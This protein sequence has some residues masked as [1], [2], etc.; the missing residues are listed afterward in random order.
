MSRWVVVLSYFILCHFISSD[1]VDKTSIAEESN[2]LHAMPISRSSSSIS[3]PP[4]FMM[5]FGSEEW[6]LNL[7]EVGFDGIDPTTLDRK[8]FM[9]WLHTEVESSIYRQAHSA[10]YENREIVPH[11]IG[12]EVDRVQVMEWLDQPHPYLNQPME[13]P[14]VWS[15]PELRTEKLQE[16]KQ[17]KL[18]S[19][20]TFFN[21]GSRN[22]SHNIY[23]SAAAIDH[24]VVMP[25][26]VFSFNQAVGSRSMRKGYL[27][28]RIIM[29][30]KYSKGVGGGICQTSS[31]LFNSA[32]QAG[33]RIIERAG[34]SKRVSYVPRHRDATVSWDGPDLKFQ[35][36]LNEPILIEASV[37]QG[38][39]VISIYG[40]VTTN[41][42]PR[43]VP[44]LQNKRGR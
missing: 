22:R 18:G 20:T 25:G 26:E 7:H 36:Q 4:F 29:Q 3:D 40:P 5:E 12:R 9:Q 33:L 2:R 10:Y 39:L 37:K 15:E 41:Y 21:A 14:V 32:D 28:A 19:Y 24:K 44:S 35:N 43:S 30:G 16:L 11:E 6:K 42:H 1:V 17:Q 23:L 13:L 34:H 8:A 38:K 27:P 31:T